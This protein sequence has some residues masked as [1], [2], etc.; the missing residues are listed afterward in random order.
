MHPWTDATIR[1]EPP[2]AAPE[3]LRGAQ[4]AVTLL[5]VSRLAD[6][7]SGWDRPAVRYRVRAGLRWRS[8]AWSCGLVTPYRT[9]KPRLGDSK[10]RTTLC[11]DDEK[12]GY[13]RSSGAA[14]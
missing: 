6:S 9:M 10:G 13:A 3:A 11:N 4:E 5:R 1:L 7:S 2:P 14:W 12:V 8:P